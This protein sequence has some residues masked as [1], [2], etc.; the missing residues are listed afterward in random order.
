MLPDIVQSMKLHNFSIASSLMFAFACLTIASGARAQSKTQYY[1]HITH[2]DQTPPYYFAF[3]SVSS[4]GEVCTAAGVKRDTS[5]HLTASNAI[6]RN[7]NLFFRST[8]GGQ[9]WKEQDPGLPHVRDDGVAEIRFVQQ[10]DSLDA[11]G[12]GDSGWIVRTYDGGNTWVRQDLHFRT[13]VLSIHFS[14]PMTGI[15]TLGKKTTSVYGAYSIETTHDGG[16]TWTI[17]PFSGWRYGGAC[18]SDGGLKFR[19]VTTYQKDPIYITSDDWNTVDSTPSIVPSSDTMGDNLGS[20][21]FRGADTIFGYGGSIKAD[22]VFTAWSIDGGMHWVLSDWPE[23]Q[24]GATSC[25]SLDSDITFL[26]LAGYQGIGIGVSIDHGATWSIDSIILDSINALGITGITV[27]S[28][29]ESIAIFPL[30]PG[31]EECFLARGVP[32]S[33]SVNQDET[34][35][36]GGYLYPNPAYGT[37]NFTSAEP[38]ST[39]HLRDLLGRDVLHNK[40]PPS[41]TL[42]LDVSHL[43]RGIYMVMF[44]HDGAM[45]PAGRIVLAGN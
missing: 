9:T 2:L 27:T 20:V 18:H 36:A 44:E 12:A 24:M 17:A 13:P 40:V 37:L 19:A 6:D 35:K 42:T 16:T 11:V 26:G 30:V 4:Y 1:W 41:G 21:A 33:E 23:P 5:I 29:K 25:S 3:S 43:P 38:G 7:V 31:N 34:I 32:A 10:I 15:V 28:K 45:L 8:D 22:G 14:D 39:M